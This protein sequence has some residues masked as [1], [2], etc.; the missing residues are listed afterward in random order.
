MTVRLAQPAILVMSTAP[1]WCAEPGSPQH[2]D[3]GETCARAPDPGACMESYGFQCQSGRT[4]HRSVEAQVLGC[5]LALGDGNYHFVQML[6]D[7]GGWNVETERTYRPEYSEAKAPHE[8][9]ELAL[10]DYIRNTME[11]YSPHSSGGMANPGD[12]QQQFE[13]GARRK[14]GRVAVRAV[15]GVV[16]GPELDEAVS[17]Q[18]KSGCEERLLRTVKKLSQPEAKGSFRVP[19]TSEFDWESR[20]AWLASGDRVLVWE[21]RYT[22]TEPHVPCLWISDCCSSEGIFYLGSCRTP[23]AGELQEIDTC[24]EKETIHTDEFV[25]CLRAAGVRAGCEDQADGSQICH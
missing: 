11:G 3:I 8:D 2:L 7:D 15:C 22:F 16:S 5:N 12:L 23:T 20:F 24:L 17:E 4:P 18:L 21:G 1:V 13:T 10:A 6:Y 14:D 19:G 9:S 25:G